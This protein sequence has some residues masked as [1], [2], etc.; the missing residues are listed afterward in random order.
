MARKH[1][2]LALITLMS[3]A[4]LVTTLATAA[5]NTSSTS[6]DRAAPTAPANRTAPTDALH[7]R[8][9]NTEPAT[10]PTQPDLAVPATPVPMNLPDEATTGEVKSQYGIGVASLVIGTVLIAAIVVGALY[11][12]ARRSWTHSH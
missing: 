2:T 10:T 4:P 6:Q 5:Q 7:L 8:Q 3:S 11:F 1:H 12:I 9:M